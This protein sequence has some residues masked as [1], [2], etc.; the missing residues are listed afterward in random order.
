[1]SLASVRVTRRT[2]RRQREKGRE[3]S[4]PKFIYCDAEVFIL[5][6]AT[7]GQPLREGE[8]AGVSSPRHVFKGI[9]Q[10]LGKP[11]NLLWP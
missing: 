3:D 2:K 9:L 6:K 7:F 1:M 4:A 5:P 10:N 11:R 8:A